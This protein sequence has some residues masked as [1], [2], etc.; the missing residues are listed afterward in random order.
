[1]IV[2][3]SA[4]RF[5]DFHTNSCGR[6]PDFN[7]KS[8]SRF[9]DFHQIC[10]QKLVTLTLN[11]PAE[12]GEYQQVY[13]LS[14]N[15]QCRF[16]DIVSKSCWQIYWLFTKSVGRNGGYFCWQIYW[17][18]L[19]LPADLL[20]INNFF[21]QIWGV[22]LLVDLLTHQIC[23]QI[24]WHLHQICQQ[25]YWVSLNLPAEIGGYF[26]WQ[27]YWLSPN[28]LA[29]LVTFTKCASRFTGIVT[30]S[31]SRFTDCQ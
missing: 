2:S 29:D 3:K 11:L 8:A 21:K 9:T 20:T 1:M 6:F 28:L 22:F 23:W 31:A 13:W 18:S 4:G 26:Y 10:W 15:L 30:K 5:T 7:T 14:I 17:L 19:N 25:T 27:I 16:T 12:M 24:Y